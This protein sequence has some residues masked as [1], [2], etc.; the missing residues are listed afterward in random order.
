MNIADAKRFA[1]KTGAK[2]AIPVHWGMFDE[3]NPE[4]FDLENAVI[5]KIY[6]E[7]KLK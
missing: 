2:K 5:P 3:L 6:E 7:V 1:E 4:N